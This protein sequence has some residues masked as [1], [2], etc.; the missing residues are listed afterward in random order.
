MSW[1]CFFFSSSKRIEFSC[2]WWSFLL[3]SQPVVHWPRSKP[4]HGLSR[5]RVSNVVYFQMARTPS[6]GSVAAIAAFQWAND[7]SSS[8]GYNGWRRKAAAIAGAA[9]EAQWGFCVF[10]LIRPLHHTLKAVRV[11]CELAGKRNR[12]SKNNDSAVASWTAE[13]L[14]SILKPPL[15]APFLFP[16]TRPRPVSHQPDPTV[17]KSLFHRGGKYVLV[18]REPT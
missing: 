7:Y 1:P 4:P 6:A 10:G 15:L 14:T 5:W 12:E 11:I 16:P 2:C 9:E 13:F 8:S 3:S 17:L 18:K